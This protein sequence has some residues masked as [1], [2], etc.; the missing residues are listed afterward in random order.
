LVKF[1]KDKLFVSVPALCEGH[2]PVDGQCAE[3][4]SASVMLLSAGLTGWLLLPVGDALVAEH[5]PEQAVTGVEDQLVS[6]FFLRKRINGKKLT[7]YS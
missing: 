4:A 6:D 1:H 7:V 3:C 5:E 2:L